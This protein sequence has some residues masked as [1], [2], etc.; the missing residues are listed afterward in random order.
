MAPQQRREFL[1]D[2]SLPRLQRLV[3]LLGDHGRSWADVVREE[4]GT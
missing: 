3:A 2:V 4:V 1:R